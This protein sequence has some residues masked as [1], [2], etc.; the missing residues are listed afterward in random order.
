MTEPRDQAPPPP[1]EAEGDLPPASLDEVDMKD[2]LRSALRPPKG[3]VA[4]DLVRGVQKRIRVRS[5]GKFYGDGWSVSRAPRSTY[6]I[7][8]ILMLAL[9]VLIFFVLIPWGS[10]ALP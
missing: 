4:P 6:L 7:T 8:S 10:G 9:T 1:E 2:L 3:S 5:R